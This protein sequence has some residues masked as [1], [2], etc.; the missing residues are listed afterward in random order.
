MFVAACT[1]NDSCINVSDHK[2]N[3]IRKLWQV[4]LNYNSVTPPSII[5][6][7]SFA[8]S[9]SIFQTNNYIPLRL[10][11]SLTNLGN[12]CY[13]NSVLQILFQ[14]N[15]VVP[16]DIWINHLLLVDKIQFTN[17]LP[18]LCK[19]LYLCKLST[20]SEGELADLV[21]LLKSI[22][23]FFHYKTQ[24]DAHEALILLLDI[25]SNI[26]NLPLKDNKIS[27]VPE[28]VDSSLEFTKLPLFVNYAKKQIFTTK[29]FTI[30]LY[31]QI[32]IYFHIWLKISVKTKI[33]VV[34][35][36]PLSLV[37]LYAQVTKKHPILMCSRFC[38][39]W[40]LL[41]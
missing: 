33:L 11:I 21:Y 1:L 29:T 22:N 10:P 38:L 35:N 14:V 34:G 30:L 39:I 41:L 13:L 2:I 26:C 9:N 24:R 28:F 3:T 16:F 12:T 40:T 31:N 19:F 20:I 37:N 23:P 15:T 18:L 32:Q 7:V 5:N 36:T 6:K 27:T 8:D 25:F 17:S 4:C